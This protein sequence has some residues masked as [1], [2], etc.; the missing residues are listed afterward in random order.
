MTG[1]ARRH[2]N[3][4][5]SVGMN[6]PRLFLLAAAATLAAVLT[7]CATNAAPTSEPTPTDDA[8]TPESS[9]L[10]AA[11]WLTEDAIAI[12]LPG[13]GCKPMITDIVTG[14][15]TID[16]TFTREGETDGATPVAC[17]KQLVQRGIYLGIPAGI[18]T[19]KDVALTITNV[20]GD[21]ETVTLAGRADGGPIPADKMANQGVAATWITPTQLAVLTWGSSSCA[22]IGATSA[23]D[24][25]T[26]VVTL[27]LPDSKMCTMD[28]VPRVN[29]VYDVAATERVAVDGFTDEAGKNVV[30]RPFAEATD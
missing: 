19:S 14:D 26:T 30:V 18:D 28:L 5:H 7:G 4:E 8:T 1:I 12:S 21:S 16:V 6:A 29:L 11:N 15:Q 17:T 22:P 20:G 10:L 13:D 27:E 25:D 2:R 3:T 9:S 24:G 23:V